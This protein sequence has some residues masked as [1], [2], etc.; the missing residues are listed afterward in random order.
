MQ[1]AV[2]GSPWHSDIPAIHD[3]RIVHGS[4]GNTSDILRKT[5]VMAFRTQET[6]KEEREMG[7]TH[8]HNDVVKWERSTQ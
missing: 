4:G 7:F 6:V 2:Q 5:Y 8:S 3:E 1:K